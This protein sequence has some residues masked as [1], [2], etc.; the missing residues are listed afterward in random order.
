MRSREILKTEVRRGEAT[1]TEC[2]DELVALVLR[3]LKIN[4]RN[5]GA[6]FEVHERETRLDT[7]VVEFAEQVKLKRFESEVIGGGILAR[8]ENAE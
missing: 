4:R 1:V 7:G 6:D 5:S 8:G 2:G 3:G